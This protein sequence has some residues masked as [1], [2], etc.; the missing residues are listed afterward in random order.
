[1]MFS[2]TGGKKIFFFFFSYRLDGENGSPDNVKSRKFT[3][4]FLS[5][6]KFDSGSAKWITHMRVLVNL[7]D[8]CCCRVCNWFMQQGSLKWKIKGNE[9]LLK[10]SPFQPISHQDFFTTPRKKE[11]KNLV[12]VSAQQGERKKKR[13]LDLHFFWFPSQEIERTRIGKKC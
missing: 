2:S 4:G 7:V 8:R 13:K 11:K 5:G 10:T 1:M 9:L 12:R 6:G 3:G